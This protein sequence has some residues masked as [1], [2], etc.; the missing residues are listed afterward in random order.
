MHYLHS[1]RWQ[2]LGINIF[3]YILAGAIAFFLS[4]NIIFGQGWLGNSI[5]IKGTGTFTERS[6]KLPG[7]V[8]LNDDQFSI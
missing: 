3:T 5:G 1:Q 6:E 7:V 2:L 4:M 8:N